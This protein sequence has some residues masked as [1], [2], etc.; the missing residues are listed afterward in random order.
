M[1]QISK[2]IQAGLHPPPNTLL[3]Q[4][5][6]LFSQNFSSFIVIYIYWSGSLSISSTKFRLHEVKDRDC[7]R[8]AHHWTSCIWHKSRWD[9]YFLCWW[10]A[11]QT[12]GVQQT[13][14]LAATCVVTSAHLQQCQAVGGQRGKQLEGSR[15]RL[16]LEPPRLTFPDWGWTSS[17][18][19]T[20][21]CPRR[22]FIKAE[23]LSRSVLTEGLVS[24]YPHTTPMPD[25]PRNYVPVPSNSHITL[26]VYYRRL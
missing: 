8:F 12:A 21:T 22:C 2:S 11:W 9:I 4:R 18:F 15:P 24:G 25:K 16:F 1:A 6:V 17:F 10:F 7:S 23:A 14:P 20:Q 5:P 13:S 26:N 19:L 3:L